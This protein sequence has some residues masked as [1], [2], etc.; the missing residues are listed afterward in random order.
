M[1]RTKEEREQ[2]RLEAK[3]RAEKRKAAKAA[4]EDA[5][6]LA[7]ANN[8]GDDDVSSSAQKS[9][10][11]NNN[12][13]NNIPH[14][15]E[16]NT[17][18][19][20]VNLPIDALAKVMRYLPAREFGAMSLTCTGIN[21]VLGGCRVA[22]ISS[23]LMRR[24][25]VEGKQSTCGSMCLVGGLQLCIG[26]KEAQEIIDRSLTGGGETKRLISK[27]MKRSN[28]KK[29]NDNGDCD[30]YPGYA[31]FVEEATIGYSAMQVG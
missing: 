15:K 28:K 22:H 27:K 11:N 25:D 13:I 23:R 3:Q 14:S 9:N 8:D 6:A 17:T 20:A 12:P 10:N 29:D 30:E 18:L 4:K 26:R 19:P 31:R 24:E 7:A 2:R 5:A 16:H 21:H 1:A